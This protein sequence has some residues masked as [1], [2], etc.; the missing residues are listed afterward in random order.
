MR[1]TEGEWG[2]RAWQASWK[3]ETMSPITGRR[4]SSSRDDGGA[5]SSAG[6]PEMDEGG[7]RN[8]T[9][10]GSNAV[11]ETRDV[12]RAFGGVAETKAA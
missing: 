8:T 2:G 4:E 9:E 5:G 3:G 6:V 11:N 10:V 1:P 7:R 12:T